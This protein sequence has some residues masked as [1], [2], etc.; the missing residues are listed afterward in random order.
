MD[1]ICGNHV[2]IAD[3]TTSVYYAAYYIIIYASGKRVRAK[4]NDSL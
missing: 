4:S 3:Y 1:S 2:G